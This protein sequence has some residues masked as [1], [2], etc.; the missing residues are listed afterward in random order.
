[1]DGVFAALADPTRLRILSALRQGE[2]SVGDLVADVGMHQPGVSRHLRLLHD[3]GLVQVRKDAQRR[4]YSIRPEG[5]RQVEDWL[6]AYRDH[7]QARYDRLDQHL[8]NGT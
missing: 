1:M 5:L 4:L 3:A 2:H 8:K 6:A 7:M